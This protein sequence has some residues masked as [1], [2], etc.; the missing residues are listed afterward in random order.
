MKQHAYRGGDM[1]VIRLGP[2][3]VDPLLH[4]AE[5]STRVDLRCDLCPRRRVQK[6]QRDD[7]CCVTHVMLPGGAFV[8]THFADRERFRVLTVSQHLKRLCDNSTNAQS[9]TTSKLWQSLAFKACNSPCP[10]HSFAGRKHF[11]PAGQW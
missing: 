6:K 2:V 7:K 10:R 11:H 3:I 4:D 5:R 9:G 1:D 8:P